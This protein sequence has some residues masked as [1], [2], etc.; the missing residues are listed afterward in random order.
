MPE[1]D[2]RR[3][4]QS[5]EGFMQAPTDSPG[6]EQPTTGEAHPTTLADHARALA[7]EHHLAPRPASRH[8]LP[9]VRLHEQTLR[10]THAAVERAVARG[11][12]LT[13]DG[14][15]LLD[16]FYVIEDVLREI[17]TDLPRGFYN[18]LPSLEAGP[19]ADLPRCH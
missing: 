5:G 17:R 3:S 9:R 1:R 18:E 6:L 8:L 7:R 13:P 15:W 2:G 4:S 11:E 14:E 12:T 10:K 16:N 19:G